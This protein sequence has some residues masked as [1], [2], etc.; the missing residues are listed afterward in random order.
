M[1]LFTFIWS[2]LILIYKCCVYIKISQDARLGLEARYKAPG[3]LP[4]VS[5]SKKENDIRWEAISSI[6]TQVGYK[7]AKQQIKK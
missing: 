2:N 4:N 5:Y 7:T 1:N 6:M 3:D